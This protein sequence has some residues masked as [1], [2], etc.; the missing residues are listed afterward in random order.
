MTRNI[1][2]AIILGVIAWMAVLGLLS[3]FAPD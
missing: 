3:Q 2:V 1:S